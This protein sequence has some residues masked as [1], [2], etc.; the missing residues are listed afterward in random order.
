VLSSL[1]TLIFI[2]L[3]VVHSNGNSAEGVQLKQIC[4]DHA[5]RQMV[6]KPTRGNYLLD[7]VLTDIDSC[8]IQVAPQIADHHA[9]FIRLR[10]PMPQSVGI[11]R[12][13]WHY[14][15][16]A[17]QNIR[18]EL[19]AMSWERLHKGSVDDAASYFFELLRALCKLYIPHGDK[20][21]TKQSQPWLNQECIDMISRKND[22]EGTESYVALR[23]QCAQLLK[24][25]YHVYASKLKTRI[26]NL[27]KN[28]K[29]WWSLNRELLHRKARVS[30]VPPLRMQDGTWVTESKPKA[31]LFAQTWLAKC[32]LPAPVEDQF[33][34]EPLMTMQHFPA[35]RARTVERELRNLDIN[36]ATG[37]DHIGARIL[38][39]LSAEIAVPIAIL[40]RRILNEA[41]WP[42][43]WKVH[44][45]APVF[46]RK[47]VYAPGNY[48]GVHLTAIASKVVE[49]VIANPLIFFCSNTV[50]ARINGDF[51][52]SAVHVTSYLYAS[53]HGYFKFVV[54]SKWQQT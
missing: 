35:I 21:T 52:R 15:G 11:L 4:D 14:K 50:S 13:V 16:A 29:Q 48:R 49:R 45:L 42:E 44:Y 24:E 39:E 1:G 20:I 2:T 27:K 6:D 3:G 26:S 7:L 37:P 23:D 19:R 33:V 5:L 22:A 53:R 34:A 31:D 32:E 30:A 12:Q 28:D 41:C 10:Y 40:C 43:I 38:K 47:S 17:W 18:C 51:A 9:I 46:K 8:K 25:S 54:A 36:K